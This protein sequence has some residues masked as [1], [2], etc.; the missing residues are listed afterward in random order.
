MR[1][2]AQEIGVPSQPPRDHQPPQT[3]AI[4]GRDLNYCKSGNLNTEII[5]FFKVTLPCAALI[6]AGE[7]S[8]Y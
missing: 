5:I 7:G 8:G 4:L 2:A 1:K 6:Y 3:R